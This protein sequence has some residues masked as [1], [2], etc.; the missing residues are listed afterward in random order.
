MV[1]VLTRCVWPNIVE[2]C[3]ASQLNLCQ[4]QACEWQ[5]NDHSFLSRRNLPYCSRV[6][7]RPSEEL[8]WTDWERRL[9]TSSLWDTCKRLYSVAAC[10][11]GEGTVGQGCTIALRPSLKAILNLF[12]TDAFFSINSIELDCIIVCIV[13]W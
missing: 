6:G 5:S 11:L 2:W 10:S 13:V 1:R 8:L 3:Q 7:F 9:D 4:Q 12:L